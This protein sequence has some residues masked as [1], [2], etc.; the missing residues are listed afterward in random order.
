MATVQRILEECCF[1]FTKKW[2]PSVVGGGGWDC[3]ESVELTKWTRIL[4]K[5]SGKLPAHAFAIHGSELHD[6]LLSTHR[7]RHTAVHRLPTTARG[8]SK[9]I[10][11]AKKC[12][13]ALQDSIRALQLDELHKEIDSKIKA[14][15]L[16]KNVLEDAVGHELEKIRRQREE[17]ERM[18]KDL[19]GNMKKEDLENTSL[20]GSLL[21]DSVRKIFSEE[22]PQ[23]MLERDEDNSESK[24]EDDLNGVAIMNSESLGG[25]DIG[26]L[27]SKPLNWHA[28]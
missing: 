24:T 20:I 21:E 22:E 25:E 6:I 9:L 19:I 8:I 12:T 28:K 23:T 18:E 4:A 2:L 5:R 13:E 26:A 1:D 7:L 10:E 3:A 11:A 15:E 14:M 16:N 27:V 17:L